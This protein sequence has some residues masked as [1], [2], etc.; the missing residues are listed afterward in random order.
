MD[1]DTRKILTRWQS[2]E[3]GDGLRRVVSIARVLWLVGLVLCFFVV[4]GV[5]YGLHPVIL[6]VAAAAMGW[7]IAEGNAL[8]GRLGQWPIFR[9]Y[10][11][12]KR[13]QEDLNSD[14]KK[15]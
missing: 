12:W 2:L 3:K 9:R 4:V 13:V 8:R 6:V 11:D 10:I 7:I 15:A 14:D 5:A 1:N